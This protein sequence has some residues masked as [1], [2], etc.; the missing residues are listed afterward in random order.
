MKHHFTALI[1]CACAAM[2]T[3]PA[4]AQ[5]MSAADILAQVEQKVG[6]VNEYQAL[7]NDPDPTRSMAA[8]EIM[9]NSGDVALERMAL[10]YGLYS[11]NQVVQRTALEAFF[12]TG[13]VLPIYFEQHKDDENGHWAVYASNESGSVLEDGRVYLSKKVGDFDAG[14]GCY[15]YLNS[16]LEL[17]CFIRMS[18][19]N[20]SVLFW[21]QW[22]NLAL[23]DQGELVGSGAYPGSSMPVTTTIPISK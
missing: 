9:L 5:S 18:D 3:S 8:M 16:D 1:L 12:N 13:P 21:S 4:L 11:P 20:V 7:L 2:G 19:Q 10:D 17:D 23:N 6:G 15:L 22:H 14:K